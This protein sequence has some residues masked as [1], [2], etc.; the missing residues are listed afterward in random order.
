M[1]SERIGVSS[2]LCYDPHWLNE[3]CQQ[4]GL[5]PFIVECGFNAGA[6][7]ERMQTISP[8]SYGFCDNRSE[9]G[10]SDQT[11]SGDDNAGIAIPNGRLIAVT[12]Q[13]CP[14]NFY[15]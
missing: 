5:S 1:V 10:F 12:S 3:R 7:V 6:I 13:N 4:R 15:R 11:A 9:L 2:Q 8:K 14:I